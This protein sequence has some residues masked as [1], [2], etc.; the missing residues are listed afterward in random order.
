M[1]QAK[2]FIDGSAVDSS[3]IIDVLNPATEE[4]FAQCHFGDAN[5]VDAAVKAAR[6]AFPA[7]AATPDEERKA[8][9]MEIAGLI[10]KNMPDL[11][12]MVTQESG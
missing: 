6:E 5:M 12:A 4:A 9:L 3:N 7:W 1:L 8:M 2:N 11:M 10:E